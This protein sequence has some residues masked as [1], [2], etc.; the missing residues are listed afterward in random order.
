[1]IDTIYKYAGK[2]IIIHYV[3]PHEPYFYYLTN[4]VKFNRPN[5]EKGVFL[6]YLKRGGIIEKLT[7]YLTHYMFARITHQ[8]RL[9]AGFAWYLR[10]KFGLPPFSPMDYVR[11]KYG[12]YK[13]RKAYAF[14][15]MIVLEFVGILIHHLDG[16]IIITSDHGE[17]LGEKINILTGG[18]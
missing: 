15:L 2:R 16:K 10:E 14:N 11:R 5:P 1:M 9:G 12:V 7:R 4:G 3:Q 13:L 6:Q 8:I 17:F 18:T